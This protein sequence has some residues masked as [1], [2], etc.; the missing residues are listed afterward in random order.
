MLLLEQ[1]LHNLFRGLW[2]GLVFLF[3]L[4]FGNF[5]VVIVDAWTTMRCRKVRIVV[6]L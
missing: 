6:W 2:F 3:S 4:R 1:A 5:I